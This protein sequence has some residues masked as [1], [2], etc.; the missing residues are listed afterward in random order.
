MTL[1]LL[2]GVPAWSG[3]TAVKEVAGKGIGMVAL[4]KIY[5]GD[6]IF[7]EIPLFVMSRAVFDSGIDN[8]EDWLNKKING[9]SS[10]QREVSSSH[11]FRMALTWPS[12]YFS[13]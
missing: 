12:R 3:Q 8:T 7:A 4:R 11:A 13:A 5:P 2:A 9:L 1:L 6:L 10:K